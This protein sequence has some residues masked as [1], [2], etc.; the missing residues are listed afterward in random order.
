[1]LQDPAAYGPLVSPGCYLVVEDGVTDVVSKRVL[2]ADPGAGPFRAADA[3]LQTGAPFDV[4]SRCER[5][6]ATNNPRGYLRRREEQSTIQ[7]SPGVSFR[8]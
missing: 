8:W 7:G 6:L 2:G 1:V 5:F 3:Y 4:D